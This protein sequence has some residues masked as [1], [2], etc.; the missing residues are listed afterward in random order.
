MKFRFIDKI[1]IWEPGVSIMGS[2]AVSFEQYQFLSSIGLPDRLPGSFLLG[3]MVELASWMI[4]L[5]SKFTEMGIFSGLGSANIRATPGPGQV[6]EFTIRLLKTST[7]KMI[8]QAEGKIAKEH[9]FEASEIALQRVRIELFRSSEDLRVLFD[10]IG[11]DT[12]GRI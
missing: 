9:S 2:Q 8:F 4:S 12:S 10:Q 3:G 1:G 6:L 5:E 7:E 11:P